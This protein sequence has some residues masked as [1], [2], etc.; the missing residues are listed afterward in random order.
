MVL[1]LQNSR[2]PWPDTSGPYPEF[3][4]V[5]ARVVAHDPDAGIAEVDAVCVPVT[6][7]E[8]A[9]HAVS[10]GTAIPEP[11]RRVVLP[12]TAGTVP[13]LIGAGVVP[14]AE[15]LAE[16]V[17]QIA[18]MISAVA[19]PDPGLRNL[20]AATYRAFRRRR[21]LLLLDLQHQVRLSELP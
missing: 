16:L 12:A 9:V 11:I 6:M 17:P 2:I 15:V 21:S 1:M 20:V 5:V 14:S 10:A 13:E 4:T 7:A 19:Y 8:A 18:A 3:F